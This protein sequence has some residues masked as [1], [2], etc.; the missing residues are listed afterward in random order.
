MHNIE[1]RLQT[2]VEII[3]EV[4][5]RP[6]KKQNYYLQKAEPISI[7]KNSKLLLDPYYLGLW[8][9]DGFVRKTTIIN[10]DIEVIKWLQQYAKSIGMNTTISTTKSNALEISIINSNKP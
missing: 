5:N 4:S 3:T 9:G 2:P 1:K 6:Y 8:L 10:E 7:Y